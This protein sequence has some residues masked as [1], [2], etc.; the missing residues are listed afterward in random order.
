MG[1]SDSFHDLFRV[2]QLFVGLF[3]LLVLPRHKAGG[4]YLIDFELKERFLS[5]PLLLTHL[6]ALELLFKRAVD[7]VFGRNALSRKRDLIPAVGVKKR[8][9]MVAPQELL[10]LALP[11]NIKKE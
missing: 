4:R 2:G 5:V 9:L 7:A 3:E 1:A 11:V 8:Q 6:L 10:M